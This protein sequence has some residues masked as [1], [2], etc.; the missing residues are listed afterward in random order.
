M[1]S[2]SLSSVTKHAHADS[3]VNQSHRL[4]NASSGMAQRHHCEAWPNSGSPSLYFTREQ[5]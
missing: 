3:L 2:H 4:V 5:E 1:V